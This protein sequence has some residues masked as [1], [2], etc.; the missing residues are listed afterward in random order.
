MCVQMRGKSIFMYMYV[1]RC[2]KTGNEV[3]E[4]CIGEK[5]IIKGTTLINTRARSKTFP[6]VE[7]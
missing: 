6:L 5:E 2:M 1:C 4:K 3:E 7:Y